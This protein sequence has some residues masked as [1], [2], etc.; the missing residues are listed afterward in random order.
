M[1]TSRRLGKGRLPPDHAIAPGFGRSAH[2]QQAERLQAG[3]PGK[4]LPGQGCA[5]DDKKHDGE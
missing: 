1:P 2:Q 3:Q 5:D 4:L